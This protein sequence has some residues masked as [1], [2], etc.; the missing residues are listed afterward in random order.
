MSEVRIVRFLS[1]WL[2]TKN[3]IDELVGLIGRHIA[4]MK[5][6]EKQLGKPIQPR[7]Y[8]LDIDF[9][10]GPPP[11]YERSGYVGSLLDVKSIDIHP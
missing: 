2:T 1:A 5:N 6:F 4:S 3:P 8:W 7:K 10:D 11:E 9:P